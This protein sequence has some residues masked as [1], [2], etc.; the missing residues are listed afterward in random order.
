MQ[1]QCSLEWEFGHMKT[2]YIIAKQVC[3]RQFFLLF[4]IVRVWFWTLHVC[5]TCL[6][7]MWDDWKSFCY[8]TGTTM[9]YILFAN[10][11]LNR[12]GM[13]TVGT[14][15]F[16]GYILIAFVDLHWKLIVSVATNSSVNFFCIKEWFILLKMCNF[17]WI[18]QRSDC[19]KF[20]HSS[21]KV[22]LFGG[23]S[24]S[25]LPYSERQ[26]KHNLFFWNICVYH[27][28]M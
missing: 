25:F 28:Y 6:V 12:F 26:D 9:T 8:K 24:Y 13:L 17:S 1:S 14:E 10:T 23:I 5:M 7:R 16:I 20:A 19:A 22:W 15:Q 11:N 2:N 21:C 3:R 27:G 18:V 4:A